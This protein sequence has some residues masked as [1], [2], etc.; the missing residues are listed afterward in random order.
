MICVVSQPTFLPWLGWFDLADQ[1]DV[2]VV[3]DD[4]AF[5]RQSWQQRNRIRTRKGLEYLSVP[6]KTA[7]RFG[8][9]IFECELDNRLFVQK[10][11]KSLQANYAKAPF[12]SDMIDELAATMKTAADTASLA[13]LNCALIF[14][15]AIKLEVSTPM[16]RASTLNVCGERGEHVAAICE[17]V[18]ANRYLSPAGAESY[19]VEDEEAF[20]RRSISIWIHEYE[21]P[22]YVQCFTPFMPYACALDL[23]FNAGTEAGAVMRSGRRPARAIRE[24]GIRSIEGGAV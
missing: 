4:V 8:Q 13:E 16:I 1:A 11:L 18:G 6:V 23:V 17:S 10:M 22:R 9:K 12:F 14:W 20:I 2:M 15:L 24:V 5:S 3:L 21:H 7:G 19:L